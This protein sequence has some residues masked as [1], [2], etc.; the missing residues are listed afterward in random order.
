MQVRFDEVPATLMGLPFANNPHPM[1]VFDSSTLAFLEVN[2]APVRKYGYSREQFLQMTIADI[3]PKE[4]V[5]QLLAETAEPQNSTA[6]HWRHKK[7]DGTVFAVTI[8]SGITEFQGTRAE[9]VLARE[10]R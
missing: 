6:E 4:D 7:K 2:P 8:T 10:A 9:L 3:R 1:W 5:P